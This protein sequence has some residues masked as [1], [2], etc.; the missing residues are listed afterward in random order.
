MKLFTICLPMFLTFSQ[1]NGAI[2]SQI[3]TSKQ[4]NILPVNQVSPFT[5][6]N[7]FV[8]MNFFAEDS[9]KD[10]FK[11]TLINHLQQLGTVFVNDDKS[12]SE[13]EKENKYRPGGMIIE[14]VASNVYEED[15][16][17]KELPVVEIKMKIVSGVEVLENKSQVPGIIWEEEKFI[18]I[19][20]DRNCY[21][22]KALAT[23]NTILDKFVED[24]EKAN[25]KMGEKKP[26]F[27]LCF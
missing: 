13:K 27:Y 11:K 22:K 1:L 26:K 21:T 8:V 3:K 4:S 2:D 23:M 6:Q 9:L 20:T 24:Y 5:D 15:Q 12:L 16:K 25:A 19:G 7:R 17:T 14:I 10:A 18:E